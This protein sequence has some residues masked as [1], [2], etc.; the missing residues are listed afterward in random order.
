VCFYSYECDLGNGW[1]DAEAIRGGL[2]TF[3][4]MQLVDAFGQVCNLGV[5]NT[6]N[7]FQPLLSPSITPPASL[8]APTNLNSPFILGT[9]LAQ[10]ARLNMEFMANYSN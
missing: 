8:V 6:P 7:G 3:A 2:V 4:G 9:R 5:P 1:E 10:S